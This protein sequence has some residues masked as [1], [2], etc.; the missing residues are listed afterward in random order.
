MI[1]LDSS[2][3]R[4]ERT[5]WRIIEDEGVLVDSDKGNIIHL[6]ETGAEIWKVLNESRSVGDIVNHVCDTF[7]V[8]A[9]TAE[10]DTLEFLQDLVKNGV[11]ECPATKP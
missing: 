10:K 4:N 9:E 6:N 11:A 5:A 7:T 2:I 3:R 1:S 8:D